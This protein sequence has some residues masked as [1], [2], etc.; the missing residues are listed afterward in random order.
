MNVVDIVI[1]I[2]TLILAFVGMREGL[3]RAVFGIIGLVAGTAIAGR[4]SPF[5]GDAAWSQIATYAIV[6]VLIILIALIIASVVRRVLRTAM[7][8]WADKLGGFIFGAAVGAFLCATIIAIILKATYAIPTEIMGG[9]ITLPELT[10]IQETIKG[11][12][13]AEALLD[14]FPLILGL[15]P[16]EYGDSVRAVFEGSLPG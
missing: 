6:V 8:G 15:L 14:R 13:L 2:V 3:I 5:F 12:C 11:S 10:A 16:G 1:I 7:L 4:V 9:H